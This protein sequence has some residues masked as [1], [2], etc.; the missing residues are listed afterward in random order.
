MNIET[1]QKGACSTVK[2]LFQ[3]FT[4]RPAAFVWIRKIGCSVSKHV[5]ASG[6][7]VNFLAVCY[8]VIYSKSACGLCVSELRQTQTSVSQVQVNT[9]ASNIALCMCLTS[10]SGQLGVRK[11]LLFCPC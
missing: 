5:V 11:K 8:S 6:F 3:Q 4:F 9:V 1:V 7:A 10:N 2:K